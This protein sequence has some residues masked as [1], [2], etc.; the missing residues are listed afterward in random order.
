M[1]MSSKRQWISAITALCLSL[2]ASQFASAQQNSMFG[3]SGATAGASGFNTGTTGNVSTGNAVGSAAFTK[4]GAG[5]GTGAAA[6]VQAV[7]PN[8][9][10]LQP[11][12]AGQQGAGQ[13]LFGANT[14]QNGFTGGNQAGIQQ[15]QQGQRGGVQGQG[16]NQGRNQQ[17]R[18]QQANRGAQQRNFQNQG[19]RGNQ[20]QTQRIRPQ[21]KVNF[22]YALPSAPATELAITNRFEKL[23]ARFE[24]LKQ[25]SSFEGVQFDLD[26]GKVTLRGQVDTEDTRKLAAMLVQIEPGVRTVQNDLT[27]RTVPTPP[28]ANP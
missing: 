22:D 15:G 12:A 8:G 16:L 20:Q 14:G 3:N 13:G 4:A 11:G 2:A 17:G 28:E 26:N 24:K 21:L 1:N 5:T 19:A 9:Q 10:P 25:K 7:G 6:G 27:V 18:N 23:T